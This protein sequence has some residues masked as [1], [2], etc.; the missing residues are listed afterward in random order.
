MGMRITL[1]ALLNLGWKKS[2]HNFEDKPILIN[3]NERI[4][5]DSRRNAIFKYYS[6]PDIPTEPIKDGAMA[7]EP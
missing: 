2:G 3:G 1:D 7:R 4:I 6:V 5:Y